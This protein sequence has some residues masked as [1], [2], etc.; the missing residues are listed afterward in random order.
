[1]LQF[2]LNHEIVR[3]RGKDP[4][5]PSELEWLKRSLGNDWIYYSTGGYAGTFETIDDEN[6]SFSVTF[7][8][9]TPYNEVFK[10]TGEY[11]LPELDYGSNAIIGGVPFENPSVKLLIETW[12]DRIKR[13]ASGMDQFPIEC[14]ELLGQAVSNTP[15]CLQERAE[16][17]FTITKGRMT[18]LPPDA[19]H[20]NYDLIP[21]TIAEGCLY[22]CGFCRVKNRKPFSILSKK[23][24]ASQIKELKVFFGPDPVNYN[25]VFLGDHDALNA[26][27]DTIVFAVQETAREFRLDRAYMN[28]S[29]VFMFGSADA[30]LKA[31][32]RLFDRMEQ[33]GCRTYI[34][35]GLESAHQ[36]T[37]DRIGKPITEQNVRQCFSRMQQINNRYEHI[38][39]TANFL[40]DES[41]PAGHPDTFLELVTQPLESRGEY[42]G[43]I[44]LSPLCRTK[45]SRRT[46]FEF[47][48]LKMQS[49]LPVFLYL[50]QRL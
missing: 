35:L 38:E 28:G 36:G 16:R 12:Y 18:V 3:A 23:E 8:I 44:Y 42:K 32:D 46:L 11:Y 26:P 15:E 20:V 21:L 49:R 13:I 27:A 6:I 31:E 5:W 34:N 25:S 9:P 10:A 7:R 39:I 40:M 24:I 2:N 45:P 30:F 33:T 14:R 22:K 29:N 47:N 43:T 41:L 50:I 19:R 1:M 4:G 17:L 37:L 48:R